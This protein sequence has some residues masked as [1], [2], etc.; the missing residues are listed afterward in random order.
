MNMERCDHK[1]VGVIVEN[2]FDE[3]LLLSRARYPFG[4]AAP[5]GHVDVHGGI[6]QT[7]VDE[8]SEETGVV[9]SIGALEKVID[10]LRIFNK[11]RR[12]GGDFHDWTVYKARVRSQELQQNLEEVIES[13]WV[14]RQVLAELALASSQHTEVEQGEWRFEPIWQRFFEQAGYIDVT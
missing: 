6:E 11:C 3:I 14:S 13:R 8:V 1:S 10:G 2:E 5:A 9:V 12:P 7:A 4:W